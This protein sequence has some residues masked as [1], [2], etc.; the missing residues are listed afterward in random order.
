MKN[1][2]GL[3]QLEEILAKSDMQT[4]ELEAAL[5]GDGAPE[6][7]M[8]EEDMSE[9]MPMATKPKV[10]AKS[11]SQVEVGVEELL[12][13]IADGLQTNQVIKAEVEAA[14]EDTSALKGLVLV[15]AKAVVELSK[16]QGVIAKSVNDSTYVLPRSKTLAKADAGAKPTGI[17]GETILAKAVADVEQHEG[18]G[19]FS[20]TDVSVLED[21][22][23]VGKSNIIPQILSPAQKNAL[24]LK[25]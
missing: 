4:D 6:E 10:M 12:Q 17:D 9:D 20:Q 19:A 11:E 5:E 25:A 1:K 22:I 24:G 3:A 8:T 15:L 2:S 21:L 16:N 18:R 23:N 7:D 14:R 13:A